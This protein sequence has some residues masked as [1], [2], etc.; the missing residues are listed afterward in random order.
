MLSKPDGCGHCATRNRENVKRETSLTWRT[1]RFRDEGEAWLCKRARHALTLHAQYKM[2]PACQVAENARICGER[3]KPCRAKPNSP[4]FASDASR[5]QQRWLP[6]PRR[7]SGHTETAGGDSVETGLSKYAKYEGVVEFDRRPNQQN[8][9][10]P[11]LA[12][13]SN[14]RRILRLD[15]FRG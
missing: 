9:G 8:Q 14:L 6:L 4:A 1:G 2:R 3:P 12:P 11:V 5:P 7:R 10:I 15:G 13:G